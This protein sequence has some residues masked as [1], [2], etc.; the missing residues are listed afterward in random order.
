MTKVVE[1]RAMSKMGRRTIAAR[2]KVIRRFSAFHTPPFQKPVA[3]SLCTQIRR[4][5]PQITRSFCRSLCTV[6]GDEP[7]HFIEDICRN[8]LSADFR[9]NDFGQALPLRLS[10]GSDRIYD[11]PLLLHR[12]NGFFILFPVAGPDLGS[13]CGCCA[14]E[15]LLLIR[16]NFV[17][18]VFPDDGGT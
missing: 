4:P 18:C 11:K 9:I 12:G 8:D 15:L 16:R 3:S 1:R 2:Q 14:E 6:L 13:G 17:P 10:L 7:L 5:L